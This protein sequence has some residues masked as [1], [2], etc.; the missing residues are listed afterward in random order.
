MM[1]MTVI[2]MMMM[3]PQIDQQPQQEVYLYRYSV[4]SIIRMNLISTD[5]SRQFPKYDSYGLTNQEA[6]VQ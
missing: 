4:M 6:S 3:F 1:T 5:Y 2:R